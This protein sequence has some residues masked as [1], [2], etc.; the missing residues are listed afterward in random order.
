MRGPESCH[1]AWSEL[2]LHRGGHQPLTAAWMAAFFRLDSN[3]QRR[4]LTTSQKY[5]IMEQ[6][7]RLNGV[8]KSAQSRGGG[9][10][11][12]RLSEAA[13][14]LDHARDSAGSPLYAHTG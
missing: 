13:T 14:V 6:A 10:E 2:R 11:R 1:A 4:S 8:S 3:V 5:M 9:M 7:R 12:M